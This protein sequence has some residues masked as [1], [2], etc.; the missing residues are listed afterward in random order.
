MAIMFKPTKQLESHIDE[1]LNSVSEGAIVFE[2]GVRCYLEK[3]SENFKAH[4]NNIHEL[5]HKADNLRRTIESMLYT[6]TLIPEH[7]GDVLGLLESSDEVIDTMK[8]TLDQFDIETPIIPDD[9][10]K[11]FLDLTSASV[12]S[13]ET[14]VHAIRAFFV[15]ARAVKG[16]LHKVLFFENEADRIGDN[17]K[18]KVFNMDMDLSLKFHLRYFALHVQNVSD[19]AEEVADRLAI[20]TIKRTI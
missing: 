3:D 8:E 14:L 16:H 4:L 9:L 17:L 12:K 19:R 15:E 5:E 1:F 11:D 18:R 2:E 10:K 20:Y 13:T 6:H 7:R